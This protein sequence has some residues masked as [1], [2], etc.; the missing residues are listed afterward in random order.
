MLEDLRNSVKNAYE[1]EQAEEQHLLEQKRN[2]QR[3]PFLGLSALQRF[4]LAVIFFLMVAI[5][6]IALLIVSQKI[7]PPIG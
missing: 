5:I 2:V 1:E 6:G 7:M 4:I 3:K